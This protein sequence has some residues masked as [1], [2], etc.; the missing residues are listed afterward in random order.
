[1]Y[2]LSLGIRWAF[3]GP[4]RSRFLAWA[5][6]H[7]SLYLILYFIVWNMRALYGYKF[8]VSASDCRPTCH[9]NVERPVKF[10]STHLLPTATM[11]TN[12]TAPAAIAGFMSALTEQVHSYV[13]E[14]RDQSVL[15]NAFPPRYE[16]IRRF[17]RFFDGRCVRPTSSPGAC[18]SDVHALQMQC[19]DAVVSVP[20]GGGPAD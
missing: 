9:P 10:T 20:I 6:S 7:E 18:P 5:S 19:R 16:D 14:V 13:P 11:T 8:L 4:S 1:M 12:A 2:D 17:A 3:T 15:E